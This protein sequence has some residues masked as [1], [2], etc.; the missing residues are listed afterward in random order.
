MLLESEQ[1]SIAFVEGFFRLTLLCEAAEGAF[2]PCFSHL[3]MSN[4]AFVFSLAYDL[5]KA[6]HGDE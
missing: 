4:P 1:R 3:Q 5:L 6:L 2:R